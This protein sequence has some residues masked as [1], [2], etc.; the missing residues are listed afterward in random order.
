MVSMITEGLA[1]YA[2]IKAA[3]TIIPIIFFMCF[4]LYLLCY[5]LNLNY[6][7]SQGTIY[8]VMDNQSSTTNNQSSNSSVNPTINQRLSYTAD[9]LYDVSLPIMDKNQ[10]YNNG[11]VSVYYPQKTPSNYSLYYNPTYIAVFAS[12][13]CC[14]ILILSIFW[15][16]FLST[17][18]GFASVDGGLDVTNSI[19]NMFRRN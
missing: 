17:H 3:L 10:S 6:K 1:D 5:N 18:R 4:A 2:T 14:L 11:N 12:G 9:I 19:F 8:A 13:T 15:L 16:Y 7:Y